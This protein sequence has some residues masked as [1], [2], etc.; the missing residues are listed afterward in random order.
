MFVRDLS[1]LEEEHTCP[2]CKGKM[3]CCEAPQFHVGDGLGWGSDVLFICLN[4]ECPLFVNGWEQIERQYGHSSSYRYME[5]PGGTESNLMMVGNKMAFKGSIVDPEALTS[6]NERYQ[7]EIH[8]VKAL[9]DCVAK[10]DLGPVMTLILDEAANKVHRKKAISLLVDI[11]DLSCID[12]IRNHTF[13]DSAMEQDVNLAINKL[14]KANYSKECP[15]CCEV[16]KAQ[17]KKCMHCKTDL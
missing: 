13:R 2:H 9:D 8:A 7:A 5:L 14:L 4:D 6:Q 1:F 11:N 12:P 15:F 3:D 10:S 17:A 16:I